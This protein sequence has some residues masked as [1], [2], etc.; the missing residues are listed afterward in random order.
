MLL[1][2]ENSLFYNYHTLCTIPAHT[3]L[4]DLHRTM[5]IHTKPPSV[6]GDDE[7]AWLGAWPSGRMIGKKGDIL[8]LVSQS[9]DT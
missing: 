8:K 4:S 3:R 9:S 2:T 5:N 6:A 1:V 7:G